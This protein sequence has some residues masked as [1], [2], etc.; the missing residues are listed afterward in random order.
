MATG[1]NRL[2]IRGG[3]VYD[4]DGDVHHPAIADIALYTNTDILELPGRPHCLERPLDV[5]DR[6]R[7]ASVQAAHGDDREVG[8]TDVP[9]HVHR[10]DHDGLDLPVRILGERPCG[11]K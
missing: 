8:L 5:E 4:H 9:F 3:R 10:V 2:L 6:I 11:R 7:G 1:G